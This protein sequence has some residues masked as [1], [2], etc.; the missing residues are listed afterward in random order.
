MAES[1]DATLRHFVE[2]SIWQTWRGLGMR[3]RGRGRRRCQWPRLT[4]RRKA[5]VNVKPTRTVNVIAALL[6]FVETRRS[7]KCRHSPRMEG[8]TEASNLKIHVLMQIANQCQLQR[9]FRDSLEAVL[10][11][12]KMAVSQHQD[13]AEEM[14]GPS[15]RLSKACLRPSPG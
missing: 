5:V 12:T 13:A 9:H 14:Y 11:S 10:I 1:I 7:R 6:L 3:S 8:L 4:W 2:S 15:P